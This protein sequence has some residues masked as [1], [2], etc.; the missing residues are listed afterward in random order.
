MKK[1]LITLLL[2][3][4]SESFSQW[5]QQYSGTTIPLYRIKFVNTNTGWCCGENGII[6]KTTNGGTN[7]INQLMPATDKLMTDIYP[8]NDSVVYAVGYF[9]TILKT[10]NGGTNWNVIENGPWGQGK[11]HYSCFFLNEQTGWIGSSAP[12]TKKT[13]DGGKSFI[14]LNVNTGPTDIFFKDS[15]NGIFATN[16]ATI[17]MTTNG[18]ENWSLQIIHTPGI[19]DE[20]F[21]RISIINNF[22]GF[23]VGEQ[24][25]TYRTTNF[26]ISWDSMGFISQNSDFI[27]SSGFANDS[28]GYA[29]GGNQIFKTTNSGRSWKLQNVSGTGFLPDVFCYSDSIVWVVGNPG[30]IWFTST[31]GQTGIRHVSEI[32]PESFKLFQNYPNPFNPSTIINYEL[33]NTNYVQLIIYKTQG[34]EISSLIKR[35]Q[36][37][38]NYSVNF[39]SAEFNLAS[40]MY[41]YS[42]ILDGEVKQTKK[43]ILLK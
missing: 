23:V 24:G 11:S 28:I 19:G 34:K 2:L 18:G 22:T 36:N 15:L 7:W 33:R 43:M 41:Y 13:T 14:D 17:G 39:N 21:F 26:G 4:Y 20:R 42:L 9:R 38:G 31:G 16:G 27:H 35:N 32:I 30:H 1:I 10:T 12:A 29:G 40:G 6:L 5:I 8:V 37:A 25:T 3:F